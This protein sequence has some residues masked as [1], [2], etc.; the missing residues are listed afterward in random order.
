VF[1]FKRYLIQAARVSDTGGEAGARDAHLSRVFDFERYLIR[2]AK[3]GRGTLT[4]RE[5]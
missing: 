4:F 2:A 1:D 5:F 3:P